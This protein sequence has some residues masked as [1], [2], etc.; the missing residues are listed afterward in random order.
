MAIRDLIPRRRE[1]GGQE[2]HPIAALHREM[3]RVFDD[4]LRGSWWPLRRWA[5]PGDFLPSVDVQE[6]ETEI[7]VSAE[8]PGMAESDIEVEL[9]DDGLVIRGEK[10]TEEE[11]TREGYHRSERAY[12]SFERFIPV[13]AEVQQDQATAEVKNGVLLVTLPKSAG[14]Q[15]KRKKIEVKRV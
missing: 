8:I 2:G 13:P 10:K 5:G 14:E 12:G 3:N 6:T 4:F 1:E 7:R 15:A 11:E 9:G